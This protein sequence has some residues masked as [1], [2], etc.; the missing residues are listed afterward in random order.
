MNRKRAQ[1]A[2]KLSEPLGDAEVRSP[3]DAS[4]QDGQQE[5]ATSNNSKEDSDVAA[6]AE[7]QPPGLDDARHAASQRAA[8]Q[9]DVLRHL[10]FPSFMAESLGLEDSIESRAYVVYL[11][12]LLQE[13]G[14][15]TDPIERMM[16]EQLALAHLRIGQL[17]ANAGKSKST[18]ACKIY[19]S[20]ASRLLGEFRRTALALRVYQAHAPKLKSEAKLKILKIAE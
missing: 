8:Y 3:S 2:G 19:T 10:V 1:V 17:H 4:G 18:E 6:T 7:G 11:R 13:A 12:R 20:G 16:L 9:A 5:Q 15:P 14:N